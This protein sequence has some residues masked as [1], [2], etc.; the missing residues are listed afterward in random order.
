MDWTHWAMQ[1]IAPSSRLQRYRLECG[2]ARRGTGFPKVESLDGN[3]ICI[4]LGDESETIYLGTDGEF[5]AAGQRR[6]E[7]TRLW[8]HCHISPLGK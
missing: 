6:D 1:S 5:Q 2:N 7:A 4:S 3:T 8:G